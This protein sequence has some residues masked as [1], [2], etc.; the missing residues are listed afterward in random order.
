MAPSESTPLLTV[1][2]VRQP[3]PRYT[4]STVRRFCTVALGSSIAFVFLCFLFPI[5]LIAPHRHALLGSSPPRYWPMTSLGTPYQEFV[6]DLSTIP[7]TEHLQEW[8]RYYASGPHLAGKNYSQAVWTKD[9]WESWGIKSE[10]IAYDTY[11]NYPEDH[12]LALIDHGSVVFEAS[13]EEDVLPED[14]TSGLVDRIPTFHGYSASGNVTAQYIFANYGSFED[15][16]DLVKAGIKIK[17]TIVVVKYG[18]VFRGLKVKRAEELGAVGVLIYSD[19]GDD[20]EITEVNGYKPYPFGPARNPSSVQR[21]S[22][23][24]IGL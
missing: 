10:I 7:N 22:V 3:H 16:E 21:G 11:I 12:R 2:R 17:G 18:R 4:H 9:L 23:Q 8:S 24:Y 5:L 1:V 20:G 19:P 13:L 15:F 14:P 6:H